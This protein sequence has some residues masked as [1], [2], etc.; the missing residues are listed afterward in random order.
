MC[1]FLRLGSFSLHKLEETALLREI[2]V[3]SSTRGD[4]ASS[5]E[6]VIMNVHNFLGGILGV[7]SFRVKGY[8]P[9]YYVVRLVEFERKVRAVEQGKTLEFG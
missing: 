5:D 4:T 3:D 9:L 6:V 8:V 1:T 2:W 7:P